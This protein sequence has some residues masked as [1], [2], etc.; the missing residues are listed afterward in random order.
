MRT[1]F[2][3]KQDIIRITG[4]RFYKR[5]QN[6]FKQNRVFGL[7]YNPA[8]NSWRG[9][10]RGTETYSVRIFFFE[11]DEL[12]ASCDCPAYATHYTCKHIAAILL[13]ISQDSWKNVNKD[14]QESPAPVIE[15]DHVPNDTF[16][17]RIMDAFSTQSKP[18]A[19]QTEQLEVEYTIGSRI[20]PH[21]SKAFL[22]LE[23]KIGTSKL[24]VVKNIREFLIHVKKAKVYPLTAKFNYD[25]R[26]HQF[27]EE[28]QYLI[29]TL[30]TAYENET[31]FE[32]S[33]SN[34]LHDK[35]T[36]VIPPGIA[37]SLLESISKQNSFYKA[38]TGEL[39][40]ISIQQE[41]A[42]LDFKLDQQDDTH[43][44]IDVSMLSDHTYLESYRYLVKQGVFYQIKEEQQKIIDQLYALLPYRNKQSHR[45]SND[46]IET[47]VSTV[48]PKLEE[49]GNVKLSEKT[50]QTISTAPL[51]TKIY[52][53][54][55]DS[56]LIAKAEFHYGSRVFHPYKQEQASTDQIVKRNMAKE[57]EVLQ[58][59]EQAGFVY[60]KDQYHL[61]KNEAI[62][63]FL[64][65][66]L[67]DLEQMA[68]VYVANN[69]K[70]MIAGERPSLTSKVNINKNSG[71]LDIYFDMEGISQGDVQQV[72]QAMIEKKR[73]FRI[74]N[75]A[76]IEL[77]GEA[78]DSF[79]ELA[80]RLQLNKKQVDEAHIQIPAARSFQIEDTLKADT[81]QFSASFQQLLDELKEPSKLNFR[82][83]DHLEAELR[84]YQHVGY[85]WFRTLSHYHLGGILADDMGLGKTIQTITYLLAEKQAKNT[86]YKSLVVAPAS[87]LYNWK[88]E[89]EKFAPSLNIQVIAGNKT[90]RSNL[91]QETG[92]VDVYITSYPLLRVDVDLYESFHFDALI[93]D[94]AQAIKNHLTQTAKAVRAL[95]AS[96]R[97]ALS[98]TPIENSLDELWSL[99]YTISPGLFDNKKKFLQLDH[100]YISKITR[101]FILRRL[102]KDVLD[103]LPDKIETVQYSDLT[104]NQ[105]Q[106]YIAYVE[107][108]QEQI[109]ET[110]QEKGF[111][112][113]KLEILAGLTRLRQICCHPSLFLENYTGQSGK[114]EQLIEL[115]HDLKQNGKRPLIFSQFSSML[116]IINQ[117]LE[118]EDFDTFYLDGS[119]ASQTR[120]EMVDRFNEGEKSAFLISLRAGGTGLNLTG[121]DTVILYDLWWNPAVEEQAAG[122]AH[123]I[124]QKNVV[125]VIRMI[126]EG[127]IEEKIYELQQKKREL[128]DQIIQPGE[129][130]LSK[131]SEKEL[132]ELLEIK[133]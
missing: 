89:F 94:E 58:F 57:L 118:Q 2:L 95:Q 122:R 67:V 10:V 25:P 6:Y 131:L 112:K 16:T 98:G 4:E 108:M 71:M 86:P 100:A 72:L 61:F 13:A 30:I 50:K 11:N 91:M 46:K 119:T 129:T 36:L 130:M 106:V 78:F 128:V 52:I 15:I 82:L 14:L 87:L 70:T 113:G 54:E 44:T 103:E 116:K 31:L 104:K 80:D 77:E 101:P 48:V 64:Y 81:A 47:F 18:N 17:S 65:E 125:Q 56:T 66:K 19:L 126:T 41:L 121:A 63:A 12:E 102:K 34:P 115:I 23:L 42:H 3:D 75:G 1:F 9:Q 45:I 26:I 88:K 73:Y 51:L 49:I 90:Q 109:T 69:V 33:F 43:F 84:D 53:D 127:T 79:Y 132:R 8:I 107:K 39:L 123:R 83:P 37:D 76:L 114:L 124:G 110:I 35:R 20:N 59:I 7:S 29:Q 99:F 60:L 105:K 38:Y 92:E 68:T 27:S 74:P 32:N 62:Y 40:P 85:Q 111:E 28:D 120:V 93:L 24:Y 117:R 22:E 133:V 97:F 96:Q 55:H 5:G 21:N